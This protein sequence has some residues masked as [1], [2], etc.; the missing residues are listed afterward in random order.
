MDR[1]N[2]NKSNE[3]KNKSP[4]QIYLTHIQ[5]VILNISIELAPL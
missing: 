1:H 3:T 2:L 4:A 5:D